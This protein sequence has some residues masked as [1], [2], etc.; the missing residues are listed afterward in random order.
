[1]RTPE[2]AGLAALA[3]TFSLGISSP[4]FGGEGAAAGGNGA[5]RVKGEGESYRLATP[6]SPVTLQARG[7]GELTLKLRGVLPA[8]SI[9]SDGTKVTILDN[10]TELGHLSLSI[11]AAGS[12]SARAD[13]VPS[14]SSSRSFHLGEGSHSVIVET[15][16]G[17]AAVALHWKGKH[18]RHE[19][20][21]A[22]A[23]HAA[24]D[25]APPAPVE[26]PP[27]AELKATPLAEEAAPAAPTPA[28]LPEQPTPA[29]PVAST[30]AAP[31]SAAPA[32][33][34]SP[35]L[36]ALPKPAPIAEIAAGP[37]P[38]PAQ[39]LQPSASPSATVS[40][41][42]DNGRSPLPL[43]LVGAAALCAAGSGVTL[44]L[45]VA[46]DGSYNSTPENQGTTPTNRSGML[47]TAN[48]EVAVGEI[49][50]AA[51]AA[52]LVATG[53]SLFF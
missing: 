37:Q 49:L 8:G 33:S 27:P 15:K 38:V 48:T 29:P 6:K 11:Y 7:A 28:P 42:S 46:E 26:T 22:H 4:A 31:P 24:P 45:G 52:F 9:P 10:G 23:S 1:M 2:L 34:S 20:A 14:G 44:G 47:S 39:A 30:S 21:V 18:G 43:I 12:F 36:L 35:P 17:N 51:A 19:S 13:V 5:L 32:P 50:G 25:A 53:V 41:S 3:A 40:Q 16:G